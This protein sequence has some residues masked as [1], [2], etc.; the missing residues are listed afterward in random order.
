MS[1]LQRQSLKRS[2]KKTVHQ[3]PSTTLFIIFILSSVASSKKGE[4]QEQKKKNRRRKRKKEREK[5]KS[6]VHLVKDR[7]RLCGCSSSRDEN[8]LRR[9]RKWEL[10]SEKTSA[11]HVSPDARDSTTIKNINATRIISEPAARQLN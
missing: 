9:I 2:N 6:E 7:T 3:T 10:L 5:E 11:S 8:K 4:R 1:F